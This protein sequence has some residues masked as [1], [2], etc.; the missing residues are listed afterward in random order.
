MA[1]QRRGQESRERILQVAEMCFAQDGYDATGVARICRQAGMSKGAFYHH[2]ASKQ[3]VF[4]ELLNR[5]LDRLD[6]QFAA[7][8]AEAQSV[9][10]SFARMT[11]VIGYILDDAGGQLPIFLEFLNQARREPAVW[12]A[13][14]APYRRYRDYFSEMIAEGIAEGSLQQVDPDLTAGV[15]VSLAVGLLLQSLLDPQGA[16]W[17]QVA[18]AGIDVLVRNS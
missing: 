5:W 18:R 17:G 10:E 9:P 1:R 8:R 4:I 3:A 6:A 7:I 14:I 12:E 13:T 11:E 15:L 2:F 16:D